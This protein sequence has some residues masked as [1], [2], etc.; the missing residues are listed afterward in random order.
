MTD[1]GDVD[2]D[3]GRGGGG[4][5]AEVDDE[6]K[7]DI[8]G[9]RREGGLTVVGGSD[10]SSILPAVIISMLSAIYYAALDGLNR[11]SIYSRES[12]AT[13]IARCL[14][15]SAPKGFI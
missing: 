4:I 8:E 9:R 13:Y 14:K 6:S 2:I 7:D 11:Y 10:I 12:C 3:E 15:W 1:E 5:G